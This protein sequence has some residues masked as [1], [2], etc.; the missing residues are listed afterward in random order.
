[1]AGERYAKLTIRASWSWDSF[2]RGL[3]TQE[4]RFKLAGQWVTFFR[5]GQPGQ[6]IV[7]EPGD[8]AVPREFVLHGVNNLLTVLRQ[9]IA[10]R[11]L[12]Y[13][14][15]VA[16][17]TGDATQHVGETVG[18]QPI[19]ARYPWPMVEFDIVASL[20][21]AAYDLA[22]TDYFMLN[23]ESGWQGGWE[24]VQNLPTIRPLQV[25]SQV[26]NALIYNSA[27]GGIAL[28]P[29]N[30]STGVY[31]YQW[32]DEA[33]PGQAT[34]TLLIGPRS[35]T[36]VVTDASG[37]STEVTVAVG[38]DP[39]LEVLAITTSTS[40][41]LVASGGV[42]GY[43]YQW[44]DGPTGATRTGLPN[45]TYKCRVT[46]SRGATQDIEITLSEPPYYW[47]RNAITLALDAGPAYRADPSSKPN[48]SFLCEVWVEQG[49]LSGTFAQV[50]T[51]LEQPADGQGRT[52][53]EVQALLD[54]FLDYHV[55]TP[56]GAGA[57]L[58]G[59]LFRRFYLK[60][61]QQYG[62]PPVP[63]ASTTLDY[64]YVLRGGLNF[65]QARNRAWFSGYHPSG[66]APFLTWEPDG[67]YVLADQPEYL[68]YLVPADAAGFERQVRLRFS[69]GTSQLVPYSGVNAAVRANEVYCLPVSYQAL[70]L[71]S[72]RTP[73][74]HVSSW[75]VWVTDD[76]GAVVSETRRYHLDPQAYPQRRYFL[77]ATSLGGMATYAALGEAQLEAEVTGEELGRTLA[78]D[79][80]PLAGDVA[81][82]ERALRPVLK[83]AAGKR[84]QAQLLA[85]QD[86][87]LSRRVLLYHDTRWVPGFLK[88]KT[89]TLWDE[90]KLVQTQEFEFTLPT[91]RLYTPD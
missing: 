5:G 37:A 20:Y 35:Y 15:S 83:V 81:V 46:D 55:P 53:F 62:T 52:T 82:L 1:M 36:C 32:A 89:V 16:R 7:P 63:A 29:S 23:G 9:A 31:A 13:A 66:G 33:G 34:R 67:K 48:L 18:N 54:V 4:V 84:T 38:S 44:A 30:G 85:A 71:E 74:R 43:T 22:F 50:G 51:T 27:T 86:L 40:I 2:Y 11:G 60:H 69:D 77:F 91:E 61:A 57:E 73:A 76:Q 59:P 47:S 68:Y 41:E 24:I 72:L 80:D 70:G 56:G 88:A 6:F 3:Q 78:P 65:Y 58:A 12:S 17:D 8:F 19:D 42:P 14:V 49:Y 79:Y 28:V 25:A 90:S 26:T 21:D 39:R 75:E 10:Q 45:G 64:H 87:L